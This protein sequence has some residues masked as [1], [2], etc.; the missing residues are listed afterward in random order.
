MGCDWQSHGGQ[1]EVVQ[2]FAVLHDSRRINDGVDDGHGQRGADLAVELRG[3]LFDL[4]DADFE[5]LYFSLAHHTD[6]L[7]EADLTVQPAGTRI[8]WTWAEWA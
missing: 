3:D 1:V 2:L 7:I 8:A 5:L 6:G 4:T